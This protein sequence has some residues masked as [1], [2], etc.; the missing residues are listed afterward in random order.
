VT[1]LSSRSRFGSSRIRLE[2]EPGF[3]LDRAMLLVN[4]RLSS[5]DDLPDEAKD[6]RMVMR[7][8]EDI[9][10]AYF[11]LRRLPGNTRDL[12]TYGELIEDVIV[13]RVERIPG[14]AGSEF[15]GGSRRELQII[16]DPE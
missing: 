9:P 4:N 8:S 6:P 16:V 14:V 13:D 11:A 7:G 5:I 3:N 1:E 15:R 12:E 10:I 2:F